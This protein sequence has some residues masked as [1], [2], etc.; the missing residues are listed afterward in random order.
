M[1]MALF[2]SSDLGDSDSGISSVLR[3]KISS[4][5]IGVL[6]SCISAL[7]RAIFILVR[8]GDLFANDT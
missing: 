4:V 3:L 8:C 1:R 6:Q 5:K 7:I 2:D